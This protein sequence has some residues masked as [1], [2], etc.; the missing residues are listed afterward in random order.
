[1]IGALEEWESKAQGMERKRGSEWTPSEGSR[2]LTT[3][4]GGIEYDG[5]SQE[6][7]LRLRAEGASAGEGEEVRI[8]VKK[9]AKLN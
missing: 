8:R 4:V 3:V 2:S 1:V 7:V 6:A 5:R 9:E